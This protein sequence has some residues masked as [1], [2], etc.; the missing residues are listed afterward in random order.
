MEAD[1]S[2]SLVSLWLKALAVFAAY[3]L[4]AFLW[5]SPLS[6]HLADYV[7]DP[8][9]S[10]LNAWALAWDWRALT[11]HPLEL[12][13][14]NA[15]YPAQNSLAFSEHLLVPALLAGPVLAAAGNPILAHNLVLL[16]S[17]P[18]S[19]LGA[20]LLAR[21]LSGSFWAA[22]LAG[23]FFAF[24]PYRTLQ[25]TRLQIEAVMWAPFAFWLLHRWLDSG[26]WR[27]LAGLG[28]FFLLL[29]LSSGYWAVYGG[30]ALGLALAWGL[31]CQGRWASGRRWAQ[32]A[33]GGAA[34]GLLLAP[35]A[36]PYLAA[37]AAMG[38]QRGLEAVRL[39][40]ADAVSW[41][42]APP[43]LVLW[44][45]WLGPLG[46]HEAYLF[47]GLI[48]LALAAAGV[49]W[50]RGGGR[51]SPRWLYLVLAALGLLMS[52]GPEITVGGVELGAGPYRFFYEHAPGFAGL[53]TA[54]RWGMLFQLFLAVLAGLGLAALLGRVRPAWG[55]ALLVGLAALGLLVELFPGPT[56][57]AGPQPV[58][59]SLPPYTTWLARQT[60]PGAVLHLPLDSPRQD[61]YFRYLS[62][63]HWRTLVNGYSDMAS[64][65]QAALAL[66]MRDP[67]PEVVADL[68]RGGVRWVLVH[69]R[70]L[71][72][73]QGRRVVAALEAMPGLARK[74]ASWPDQLTEVFELIPPPGPAPQP[75]PGR[76]P[77]RGAAAAKVL[78][79]DAPRALDGDPATFW[80][81][82]RPQRAGDFFQL[83]WPA[84][85]EIGGVALG[86]GY[87]PHML[88]LG[89]KLE[90]LGPEGRWEAAAFRTR[91]TP[92]MAVLARPAQTP[93]LYL[94]RL[95]R[96]RLARGLRLSLTQAGGQ[97][98]VIAE[99]G[100][101]P[102]LAPKK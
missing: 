85:V 29:A 74:A 79:Q 56:P 6:L 78:A 17:F 70:L 34:V 47:P 95:E 33:L 102:P 76:A 2:D 26:A 69:R 37:H 39:Y 94:L 27:D 99:L 62:A 4:L 77:P 35:F 72:P 45:P 73:G 89:L 61:H 18:L 7:Y 31:A 21:R 19:G 46:R 12:F 97:P 83:T 16:L 10:L 82:G 100:L 98:W 43:G 24:C 3:G 91:L 92:L 75:P 71:P 58:P 20:Y 30:L 41:L 96:P 88:P 44:G 49:A 86:L 80:G 1:S 22:A 60:G 5:L 51:P 54:A 9:D 55:R 101:L 65:G 68:A 13:N 52:L 67:T 14:A 36:A 81:T 11:G 53:R 93:A 38:F 50:F 64:R 40:S 8:G 84:L 63:F 48:A 32:L 59:G 57:H 90:L 87:Q 42:A 23:L 15:F 25:I 28:L 66:V